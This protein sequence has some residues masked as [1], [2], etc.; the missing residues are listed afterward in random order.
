[1]Q[2]LKTGLFL[3]ITFPCSIEKS[4]CS[5]TEEKQVTLCSATDV[6]GYMG[7]EATEQYEKLIQVN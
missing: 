6:G 4:K 2:C 5:T 1:M 3:W 7:K